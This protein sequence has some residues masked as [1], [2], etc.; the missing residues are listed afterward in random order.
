MQQTINHTHNT[1]TNK[2][3]FLISVIFFSFGLIVG[4]MIGVTMMGEL[5]EKQNEKRIKIES[6]KLKKFISETDSIIHHYATTHNTLPE[7][8]T[9]PKPSYITE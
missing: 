1:M 8:Y 7:Y 6:I 5:I 9:R 2:Q 4:F 3:T